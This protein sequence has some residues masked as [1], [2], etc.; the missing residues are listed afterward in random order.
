[1]T[2]LLK[3]AFNKASELSD[4]DQD[5]LAQE[6]L[7]EIEGESRWDKTLNS[8]ASEQMLEQMA[9]KAKKAMDDGQVTEGGFDQL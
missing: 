2:D 6:L 8:P 3:Q 1:M 7:S 5:M 4:M 9:S